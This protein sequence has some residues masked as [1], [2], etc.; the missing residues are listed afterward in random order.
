[1]PGLEGLYPAPPQQN[2]G[3]L[4]GNPAQT[5][6][7]L[8]EL[9]RIGIVGQQAP[10]LAQQPAAA[11]AGQ[12]IANQTA[13]LQQQEAARKMVWGAFGNGLNGMDNPSPEDVHNLTVTLA[14]TY[15]QIATQ[16]PD[17]FNSAADMLLAPGGIKKNSAVMMNSVMSPEGASAPTDVG[18][19]STGQTVSGT[20]GQFNV[21]AA[22][23]PVV[24]QPPPGTPQ[25]AEA[26]QTDLIKAGNYSQDMFP[27]TQALAKLKSLGPGATGPGSEGRQELESFVYGLAPQISQ[28]LGVDADKI[29]NYADLNKYL[30]QGMQQRAQNLGPHTNEGLSTAV[31][32]S[33][34]V[35]I[36][37]MSV[38]ELIKSQVM[39]RRMEQ[40][41]TLQSAKAGPVGYTGAK[42]SFATSQ[43][44]RAYGIDLM[45]PEQIQQLQKTLK[46]ADR[47]RFNSSLKAAID[48]GVI[49]PPG[50]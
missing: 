36:N 18:V 8:G 5:I 22:G 13:Q 37:D 34:N 4:S 7:M 43:D 47:A 40:A 32:G 24:T 41:Q 39:L 3:I 12:N 9:Q 48:S 23:G 2:S 49:T 11:L 27:W 25:S 15:P 38:D 44:P 28:Y 31:T 16:Y 30:T 45:A 6:G 10:S 19:S 42:G 20:R 1:M 35:K 21:K 17:V 50:Q 29:K 46:G 26:M 14:R 33:P